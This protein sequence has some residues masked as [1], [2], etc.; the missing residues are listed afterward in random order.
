MLIFC[1]VLFLYNL[2]NNKNADI[3]TIRKN[4]LIFNHN[5]AFL[6]ISSPH[7]I[8]IFSGRADASNLKWDVTSDFER[9][10]SSLIG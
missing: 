9:K 7:G 2:R 4:F 6:Y 1:K 8:S 3:N 10:S 5:I